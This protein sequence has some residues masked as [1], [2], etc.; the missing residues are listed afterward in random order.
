MNDNYRVI[1]CKSCDKTFYTKGILT[2]RCPN[3]GR[4][5]PLFSNN[6][7][8]KTK[9]FWTTSNEFEAKK[10]SYILNEDYKLRNCPRQLTLEDLGLE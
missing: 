1:G 9:V 3:C 5:I 4:Q 8:I 2:C 7:P 6:G 10:I